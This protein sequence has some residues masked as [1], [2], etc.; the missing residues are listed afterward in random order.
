MLLGFT[1]FE[2]DGLRFGVKDF[3][4]RIEGSRFGVKGLGLRVSGLGLR[5]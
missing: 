1:S 2:L 5:F 4:F 3:M